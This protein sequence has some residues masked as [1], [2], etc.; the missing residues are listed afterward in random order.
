MN[1]KNKITGVTLT[2]L[3]FVLA[4]PLSYILLNLDYTTFIKFLK[5][6]ILIVFILIG[7]LLTA[8]GVLILTGWPHRSDGIE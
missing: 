5:I 3:G 1:M 7:S 4:V 2:L 8:T 6:F